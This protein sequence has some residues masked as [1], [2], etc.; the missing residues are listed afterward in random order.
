MKRIALAVV[1]LLAG[2]GLLRA[3]SPEPDRPGPRKPD[4]DQGR[5]LYDL[6]Y[7]EQRK[8]VDVTTKKYDDDVALASEHM[9]DLAQFPND[10]A[11][12]MVLCE[13]AFELG[14]RHYDGYPMAIAAAEMLLREFPEMCD[15]QMDRFG[16]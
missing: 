9:A 4:R 13:E 5:K 7:G 15:E 10:P 11:L 2:T 12:R 8:A 3:E 6:R 14:M 16:R 1:M